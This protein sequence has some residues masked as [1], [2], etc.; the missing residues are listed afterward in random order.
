MLT[1]K[2]YAKLAVLSR[3]IE[4]CPSKMVDLKITVSLFTHFINGEIAIYLLIKIL[5][6][7]L[8]I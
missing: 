7:K 8:K 6:G 2:N 3:T 1:S 5:C 4:S